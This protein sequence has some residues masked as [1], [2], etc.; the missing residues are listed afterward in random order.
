MSEDEEKNRIRVSSDGNKYHFSCRCLPHDFQFKKSDNKIITQSKEF[1]FFITESGLQPK[2]EFLGREKDKRSVGR[3]FGIGEIYIIHA[4]GTTLF[5]IGISSNFNKRF[6]DIA[7]T[8]PLPLMAFKYGKCDN[9]VL[10]E[11][12]LHKLLKEKRFK[13]E[14]F[15][16]TKDDLKIIDDI[17][18]KY[19]EGV[20]NK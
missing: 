17:W 15:H 16:L 5:K 9:P 7:G 12:H 8:S 2:D 3:N 4:I 10:L 18:D 1:P 11:R 14:W 19:F 13:N 6:N 20:P